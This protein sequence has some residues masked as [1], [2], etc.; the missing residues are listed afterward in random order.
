MSKRRAWLVWGLIVLATLITLV[1]SLTIWSKRQL[2]STD[3]W[4]RSSARLLQNDDIRAA[5]STRLVEVT[6]NRTNASAQLQKYLPKSAQG[7]APAIAAGIQ[8][9]ATRA[10]DTLL[11]TPKAQQLWEQANRAAHERLVAVLEKKR[12]GRVSASTGTI[13]LELGPLAQKLDQ[14]LGLRSRLGQTGSPASGEIVLLKSKDLKTAQTAVGILNASTVFLAIAALVLYALA[15]YLAQGR[16]RKFLQ[17]SGTALIFVGLIVLIVRRVVGGA[18]IDSLVKTEANRPAVRAVWFIETD[19]LRDIGL[20]LLLYGA[21]MVLA[22]FFGGP[23]RIA[24]GTR[25]V[26]T[27]AFRR[28][29]AAVYAVTA[30]VFLLFIAWGPTAATRRLGGV[31]ILAALTILAIEVWRR[32]TLREF[33][34]TPVAAAPVPEEKSE[35]SLETLERLARLR[36]EGVLSESEF[37]QQKA[38]LLGT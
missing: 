37:Q 8:V 14:R 2:L 28:H 33:P 9:A 38:A 32:Q 12:V 15:I 4:T 36:S 23:S 18:L 11:R 7:A 5:L 34:E 10:A 1:S 19:L 27:P 25:R 13:T 20:A 24:S 21:L 35:A 22:G 6:F 29:V 31:V 30:L 3:N 26:L 17:V 16:R